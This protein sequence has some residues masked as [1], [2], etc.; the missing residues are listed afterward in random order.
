MNPMILGIGG[1]SAL[2]ATAPLAWALARAWAGQN[3]APSDEQW[4]GVRV[5]LAGGVFLGIALLA[6]YPA[7]LTFLVLIVVG[8]AGIAGGVVFGWVTRA[9]G[10][11][12]RR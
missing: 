11:R 9:P 3:S 8:I 1:A 10:D 4:R 12:D 2:A 5:S 7:M 6:A